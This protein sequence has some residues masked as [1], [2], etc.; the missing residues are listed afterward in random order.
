[1]ISAP[2]VSAPMVNGGK[3]AARIG[4]K[5]EELARLGNRISESL[6]LSR[7]EGEIGK[8]ETRDFLYS[9]KSIG[10][11]INDKEGVKI[12]LNQFI[13][14]LK[15]G[16]IDPESVDPIRF[17]LDNKGRPTTLDNRRVYAFNSAGINSINAV[18]VSRSDLKINNE[19]MAK[20]AGTGLGR[21]TTV[22]RNDRNPYVFYQYGR[23]K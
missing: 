10:A 7:R 19:F 6:S 3:T 20:T 4:G 2:L 18:C 15:N 14:D 17:T 11:K 16:K 8:A 5:G 13:D 1:M 22:V 9:Q 21:M 23:K 12:S